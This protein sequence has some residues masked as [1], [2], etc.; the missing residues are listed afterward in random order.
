MKHC[1]VTIALLSATCSLSAQRGANAQDSTTRYYTRLANSKSGVDKALLE[2][3]LYAMLQSKEEKDWLT[4]RRYFYMLNKN[5]TVDSINEICLQR[6]PGGEVARLKA[7]NIVYDEKDPVKKEAAF[8]AWV[9]K[10]PPQEKKG[11]NAIEYDYA[12]YGVATAYAADS[13]VNKALEWAQQIE[14]PYWQGEGLMGTANALIAKGFRKEGF[15]LCL[16]ARTSAAKAM[17]MR[18]DAGGAGFASNNYLNYSTQIARMLNEDG[19]PQEAYPYIK[20]AYDSARIMKPATNS[21]YFT[22][23]MALDKKKEAFDIA[24][25]TIEAGQGTTAMKQQLKPL[26]L[27][28]KGTEAEYET[29]IKAV[30]NA[31]VEKTRKEVNAKLIDKPA[32][33]VSFSDVNGKP[34]SLHQLKG[35]IVVLDFWAT[36]CGPC[37]RSFPAMKMAVEKYK[38]NPD[39]QFVF[40]HTW[41]KVPK[42]EAVADAQKYL[43][44]NKYPFQLWMDLKDETTTS[45]KGV[46]GYK[47]QGIP[48]KFVIDKKGHIRFELTGFSGSDEAAVEEIAQMIEIAQKG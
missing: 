28:V 47:I 13:N 11:E 38:N 18:A 42:A 35:K 37:K 8:K 17:R 44:D 33:D 1:F 36:W 30:N 41:E 32:P 48:A 45:N 20:E 27:A 43:N 3:K 34:V 19:K 24:V 39:V 9:A 23:L 4:A 31:L 26:F 15:S 7:V 2:T 21:V 22:V 5:K 46:E 6:Y 29:F 14:N 40:I 16:Q 25:Q 12:R 10:F